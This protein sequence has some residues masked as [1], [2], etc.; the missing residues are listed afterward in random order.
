MSGSLQLT[1]MTPVIEG[2]DSSASNLIMIATSSVR[3]R[4]TCRDGRRMRAG[5]GGG[6]GTW[7]NVRSKVRYEEV[8]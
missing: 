4:R 8:T 7:E 1:T 2:G 5:L 3:T 6:D